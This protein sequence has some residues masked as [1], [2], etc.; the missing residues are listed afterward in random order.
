LE[1]VETKTRERLLLSATTIQMM[2][3][4][5]AGRQAREIRSKGK[6]KRNRPARG[7]SW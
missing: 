7:A 2:E 6:S 3:G 1:D 5:D 4:G